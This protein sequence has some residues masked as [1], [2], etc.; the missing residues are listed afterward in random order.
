M[1]AP[2]DFCYPIS[3][4]HSCKIMQSCSNV[5]R[6]NRRLISPMTYSFVFS[7]SSSISPQKFPS[8]FVHICH[9]FFLSSGLRYK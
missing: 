4:L 7:T 9:C 5:A 3:L 2:G 8:F 1:T 6:S